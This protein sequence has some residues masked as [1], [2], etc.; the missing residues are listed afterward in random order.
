M[1][2]DTRITAPVKKG[3]SYGTVNISLDKQPY[4]QRKLVAL[5]DVGPG[6]LL[7]RLVDEV[8]LL[9]E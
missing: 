8:K 3:D 2:I 9:F 1:Q 5:T 4:A 7:S 6:S